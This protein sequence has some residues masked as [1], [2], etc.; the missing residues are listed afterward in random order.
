MEVLA[1]RYAMRP[2]G[3]SRSQGQF[4]LGEIIRLVYGGQTIILEEFPVVGTRMTLDFYL[5]H[6]NIAFEFQG[7]QHIEYVHHYHRG[8]E[9]FKRQQQRDASKRRWCDLNEID[10]VEVFDKH[11]TTEQLR[12]LITQ[13]RDGQHSG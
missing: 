1:S 12:E 7:R 8:K 4:R 5:P 9:N 2:A 13:A 6:H 3:A 11:I 10:L